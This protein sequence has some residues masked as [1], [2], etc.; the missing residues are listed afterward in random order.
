[1][2]KFNDMEEIRMAFLITD[3]GKIINSDKIVSLSAPS[4]VAKVEAE[5][6]R[7]TRE[8]LVVLGN[9]QHNKRMANW[10]AAVSCSKK[11]VKLENLKCIMD[12][13]EAFPDAVEKLDNLKID[14]DLIDL[15]NNEDLVTIAET[16]DYFNSSGEYQ[17]TNMF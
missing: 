11:A 4:T 5:L 13:P 2:K 17:K 14:E 9:V 12:H 15:I 3:Y 8:N 1:M 16:H 7:G 6:E 10:V